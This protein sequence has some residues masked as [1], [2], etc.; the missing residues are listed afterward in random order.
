[1]RF[2]RLVASGFGCGFVPVA[3]G[4]VGSLV[5]LG[6]GAALLPAPPGTWPLA[7]A[8]CLAGWWAVADCGA[9]GEDPGWV[10]IDEFAGQWIAM[11]P[12]AR[13]SPLGLLAAFLTFRLF[14]IVKP[15]PVGW[16]DRHKNA[17]GVVGDDVIAGALAAVCVWGAGRAWPRLFG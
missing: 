7:L 10:V 14:D 1:M 17:A 5:A 13:A 15:G 11:A 4:T 9:A 12:L 3:P 2:S 6:I 8:A 16:A